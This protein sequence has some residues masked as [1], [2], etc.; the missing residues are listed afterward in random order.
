MKMKFDIW[1]A[2]NERGQ[3]AVSVDGANDARKT[4]AAACGGG[5]IRTVKL[6]VRMTLPQVAESPVDVPDAAGETE[7]VEVEAA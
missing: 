1:L 3:S 2:A 5:A 6:A 4:L 7:Q